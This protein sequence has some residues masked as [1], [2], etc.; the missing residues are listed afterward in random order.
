VRD[1]AALPPAEISASDARG[2]VES[3]EAWLLDV[4]ED[5]EWRAGHAASAHHI[6]MT[7]LQ[8][9]LHELPGDRDLLVI[10]LSGARSG[11]VT[12]VLRAAGLPAANVVGGM[13]AWQAV[14]GDAVR[15]DGSEGTVAH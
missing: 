13:L 10:C 14:G 9:R 1:E 4:R 2:L 5:D 7:R 3:G 15:D 11:M 12:S 8:G 6:P